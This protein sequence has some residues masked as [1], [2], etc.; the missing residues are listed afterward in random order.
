MNAEAFGGYCSLLMEAWLDPSGSLPV[1]SE[2]LALLARMGKASWAH[3]SKAILSLFE[4][5]DGRLYSPI[6][7]EARAKI[8][9][10]SQLGRAAVEARERLKAEKYRQ[11]EPKPLSD[12]DPTIIGRLSKEKEK[13]KDK[14]KDPS[15]S[16]TRKPGS[17][18][19]SKGDPA[20]EESWK[21]FDNVYPRPD[22]GRKLER[23]EARLIWDLLVEGGEEISAVIERAVAYRQWIDLLGKRKYVAMMTTWLNQRR[24]EESYDIDPSSEEGR[25][26]QASKDAQSRE[27]KSAHQAK[28]QGNYEAFVEALV[29]AGISEP[30]FEESW[31]ADAEKVLAKR[32]QMGMA[33]AVRIAEENLSNPE[34]ARLEMRRCWLKVNVVPS[35]WE[36]DASSNPEAYK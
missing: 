17:K 20:N 3:F 13:E 25:L 2:D 4:E 24:W 26:I 23:A 8:I 31:R 14:E 16:G 21:A 19:L 15:S 5:E 12:D 6:V 35:F 36:W 32:K 9:K 27:E 30:G 1:A 11:L 7:D 34:S 10:K 22:N 29:E 18:A 28:H 33:G